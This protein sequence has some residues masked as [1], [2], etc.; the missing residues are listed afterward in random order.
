MLDSVSLIHG[1]LSFA[2]NCKLASSPFEQSLFPAMFSLMF[3]A[4]LRL[5]EVTDSP[6]NL[7]YHSLSLT[8]HALAI[9]FTSFKHSLGHPVTINIK[10]SSSPACPV[11]LMH[12]Y[13]T[14]RGHGPGPLFMFYNRSPI[15]PSYFRS[16]LKSSL[17]L[18][19]LS[20]L[21]ITPH[22]FRIGAATYAAS[23][24]STSEQIK[25]LGRW[26]ST[27]FNKYIRINSITLNPSV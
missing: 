18:A 2:C 4:L 12:Y 21:R 1:E 14:L 15:T 22:S 25:T 27:A 9:T 3:H 26:R 10:A 6:H 16:F 17:A 24:G 13:L 8:K 23:T 5:G 11:R 7:Q 20:S 19:G